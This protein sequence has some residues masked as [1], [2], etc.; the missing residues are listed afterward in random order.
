MG[1]LLFLT[2]SLV[3]SA[4]VG[5]PPSSSPPASR[6]IAASP[7][8]TRR[9][10]ELVLVSVGLVPKATQAGFQASRHPLPESW[11]ECPVL[12]VGDWGGRSDWA[13]P[14]DSNG[15]LVVSIQPAGN[16]SEVSV[17]TT[18]TATYSDPFRNVPVTGPC[19][20]TGELERLLFDGLTGI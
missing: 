1:H 4:C 9:R 7:E 6:L 2:L 5:A 14:Q 17:A 11:A 15:T 19:R 20:S 3:L 12:L 18:F 16:Q 13:K 8:D 10:I